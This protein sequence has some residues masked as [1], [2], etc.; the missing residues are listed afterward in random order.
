MTTSLYHSR[1]LISNNWLR[2]WYVLKVSSLFYL[3]YSGCKTSGVSD[4]QALW[5]SCLENRLQSVI[6]HQVLHRQNLPSCQVT[7]A[8]NEC[9]N[10]PETDCHHILEPHWYHAALFGNVGFSWCLT[11]IGLKI[12][13][14]QQS[15]W[16]KSIEVKCLMGSVLLHLVQ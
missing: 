16:P 12:P 10:E 3:E 13:L 9:N 5:S 7:V 2:C 1:L 15:T 4:M 6:V 11:L 8:E 14:T